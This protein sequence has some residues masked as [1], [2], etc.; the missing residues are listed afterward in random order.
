MAKNR[1]SIFSTQAQYGLGR[2]LE[3]QG[4][5]EDAIAIY[6]ELAEQARLNAPDFAG[7]AYFRMSHCYEALGDETRVSSSLSDVMTFAKAL[8]KEIIEIEIPA[9]RAASWMRR[10]EIERAKAELTKVDRSF[11][12][13][14][15]PND[16]AT[17]NDQARILYSAGELSLET[18]KDDT[19]MS[20]IQTHEELQTYLW[21]AIQ[22]RA[23]PY[24]EKARAKLTERYG[25][26][27]ALAMSYANESKR[28]QDESRRQW[29][30]AILKSMQTLRNYAGDD[31]SK[32]PQDLVAAMMTVEMQANATLF[33]AQD[34]TPLTPEAKRRSPQK[35]GRVISKPFF[36]NEK[37][38]K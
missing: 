19:F 28:K 24:A 37:A 27:M 33:A 13:I 8:P 14:F 1:V 15:P 34:L 21:R 20:L 2:T 23:D 29:M 18:L 25:T 9:R 12:G 17:L 5:Y 32:A 7:L 22:T 38:E 26:F 10:G 6:R 30:A 31:W 4:R 36:P 3:V 35:E 11:P 16:P